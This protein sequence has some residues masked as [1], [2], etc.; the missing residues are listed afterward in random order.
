MLSSRSPVSVTEPPLAEGRVKSG[1]GSLPAFDPS[2]AEAGEGSGDGFAAAVGAGPVDAAAVGVGE[3]SGDGSGIGVEVG[4]GVEMAGTISVGTG[5]RAVSLPGSGPELHPTTANSAPDAKSSVV[6]RRIFWRLIPIPP[7]VSPEPQLRL[8]SLYS[9]LITDLSSDTP[10]NAMPIAPS[11]MP[12]IP[13]MDALD[14]ASS[15]LA[16]AS[17]A[18]C[19]FVL[20]ASHRALQLPAGGDGLR[21]VYRR[22]LPNVIEAAAAR[23]GIVGRVDLVAFDSTKETEP[24]VSRRRRD[25]VGEVVTQDRS[26]RL[27]GSLPWT[28]RT[29]RE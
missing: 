29:G 4:S 15:A 13:S 2:E 11:T 26:R 3:G 17:R 19:A 6:Q 23:P 27:A 14:T 24:V 28:R 1:A 25:Q 10:P 12:S 18:C 16:A 21:E 9:L 7:P 5:N 22:S 8:S 20:R